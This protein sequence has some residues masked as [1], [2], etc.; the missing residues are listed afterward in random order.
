MLGVVWYGA[1]LWIADRWLAQSRLAGLLSVGERRALAVPVGSLFGA[2]AVYGAA[3]V[4]GRLSIFTILLTTAAAVVGLLWRMPSLREATALAQAAGLEVKGRKGVSVWDVLPR[5]AWTVDDTIAAGVAIASATVF[6]P[7]YSLRMLPTDEAGNI[8]TA[9]SC[10]GDLPIHM[11]IA[12]SFLVG[13]NQRI[14]WGTMMSPIFAGEPMTYP[15]LPDFHAAILVRLGSSMRSAFLV[16]GFLLATSLWML[17]Y[18]FTVRVTRSRLGGV[19]SI[20]LT[21]GAGGLGA[22]RWAQ[23]QGWDAMLNADVV[24]HDPTGEWKYLWFAFVPHILLPQ[25]GGNFAYPMVVAALLLVWIASDERAAAFGKW[26]RRSALLHAAGFTATLPLMQAHSFIGVGIIIAAVAVG[27]FHKWLRDRTLL[28]SWAAAGVVALAGGY[29]QM[30]MFRHTVSAGFYG[31]FITYGWLYTKYEFGEPGGVVGFLRFWFYSL[32]P[33]LHCFLLAVALAAGEAA[34]A[35]LRGRALV[36]DHGA[37][38]V[39]RH[40]D[41]VATMVLSARSASGGATSHPTPSSGS[42]GAEFSPSTAETLLDAVVTAVVDVLAG[43]AAAILGPGGVG[44]VHAALSAISAANALSGTARALDTV[45]LCV[46]AFAVFMLGNY[47]NLQP[48]ERDNAKIFY[49]WV[50]VAAAVNG[51]LFAAPLEHLVHAWLPGLTS[52]PHNDVLIAP[53]TAVTP[54]APSQPGP[55]Q[56]TPPLVPGAESPS[57]FASWWQAAVGLTTSATRAWVSGGASHVPVVGSGSATSSDASKY[58]KLTG[59]NV[60]KA[61]LWL[62]PVAAVLAAA[63]GAGVALCSASGVVMLYQERHYHQGVL[64]DVDVQ[65]MGEWIKDNVHPRAVVMHSNYHVQASGAIAARPS[66]VSYFGWVSNHGYNANERL[67]D[68]DYAMDNALK[69]SDERTVFLFKRWGVRY[70]LGMGMRRADDVRE[71]DTFLEGKLKRVFRAGPHEL[72]QVQGYTW[73][74]E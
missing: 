30:T 69:A 55:A 5:S 1:S 70:V 41:D 6:W 38:A 17:L 31:K 54:S 57:R 66:L 8:L 18:Y 7:L 35:F 71:A 32:G 42:C 28:A 37:G 53:P 52:P 16:P 47:V 20:L 56:P 45:N 33:A 46:G 72:Y 39:A 48:W 59:G 25:R 68:R 62:L 29:P 11:T 19:A 58:H 65:R 63:A 36:R 4:T 60:A 49:I 64:I 51:A 27:D 2:W 10:Y 43:G 26:A 24:Q 15:F 14:T 40:V 3:I 23:Q 22:W 44:R 12:N 61:P 9:G 67:G 34:F 13:V 74:P 73:D 50:F 21:V